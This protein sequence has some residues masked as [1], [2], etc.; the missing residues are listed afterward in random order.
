MTWN[1]YGDKKKVIILN[2]LNPLK[3]V[4]TVFTE[5]SLFHKFVYQSGESQNISVPEGSY[6]KLIVN[7]PDELLDVFVNDLTEKFK[8][9]QC[10]VIDMTNNEQNVNPELDDLELDDPFQILMKSIESIKDPRVSSEL[11]S[12]YKEAQTM[13]K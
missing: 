12:I 10:Q 13:E 7:E 8:L 6:V 3:L 2:T 1:D 9:T 5:K 11:L 4:D